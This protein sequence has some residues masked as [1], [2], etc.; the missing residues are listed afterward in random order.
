MPKDIH[1]F[2]SDVLFFICLLLCFGV[3]FYFVERLK[4][5]QKETPYFQK[6]F[7]RDILL[8]LLNAVITGPILKL[9]VLFFYAYILI[10]YVPYQLF[11]EQIILLPYSAQIIAALLVMDF[12]IY[13]RHRF[14]HYWMWSYHSIH[15][16]SE[17]LTW[18]T[19]LRLHPGD[20]LAATLFDTVIMFIFGFNESVIF[21]AG[22]ILTIYDFYAHANLDFKL[23]KPLRYILATPHS[24][25]WHH[26]NVREAYDK[27]FCAMFAFYD[28]LFGTFYHPEELP[29][30]YGLSKGEQKNFPAD[31]LLGWLVYPIKRDFKRLIKRKK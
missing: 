12:A 24:H 5:A 16:S 7:W 20:I 11:K 30:I 3:I 23:Q 10:P 15:H 29:P 31:N 9:G 27:N 2:V 26:A 21:L 6:D 13:W 18:T 14:T 22:L 25:R 8:S 19:K 28:V 1:N 17:S 4:P